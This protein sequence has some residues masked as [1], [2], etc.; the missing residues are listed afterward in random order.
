M[1]Y[2]HSLGC[3]MTYQINYATER[4]CNTLVSKFIQFNKPNEIHEANCGRLEDQF[5]HEGEVSHVADRTSRR[6]FPK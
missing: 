4:L 3:D 6:P 2:I 1:C 5:F